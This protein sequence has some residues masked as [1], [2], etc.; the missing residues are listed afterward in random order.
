MKVAIMNYGNG[1]LTV[2]DVP[3]EWEDKLEDFIFEELKF[4]EG[5]IHWMEVKSINI[6]I[7]V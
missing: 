3:V 6:D 7:E 5:E 1:M 2:I 4:D